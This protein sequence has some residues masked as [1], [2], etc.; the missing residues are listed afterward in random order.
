MGRPNQLRTFRDVIA[1]NNK[2]RTE[3]EKLREELLDLREFVG[4]IRTHIV[5]TLHDAFLAMDLGSHQIAGATKI[6]G[7]PARYWALAEVPGSA[8]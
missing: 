1:E 3:N 6:I 2:L 4:K 5:G 8:E 7:D